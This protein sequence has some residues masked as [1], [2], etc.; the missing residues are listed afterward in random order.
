MCKPWVVNSFTG[1]ATSLHLA[2]PLALFY[3]RSDVL[4]ACSDANKLAARGGE[5]V[6]LA[7]GNGRQEKKDLKE[8]THLGKGRMVFVKQEPQRAVRTNVAELGWDGTG[9]PNEGPG[10]PGIREEAGVWTE[11]ESKEHIILR[12]LKAVALVLGLEVGVNVQHAD[13]NKVRLWIDDQGA[14]HVTQNVTSNQR[15]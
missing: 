11:N 1:V 8:W 6:R 12:D 5:R 4:N 2:L 7:G 10:E 3:T 9:G 13:V 14:Q 15:V